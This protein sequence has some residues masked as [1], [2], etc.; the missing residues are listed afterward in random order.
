MSR[1]DNA[2]NRCTQHREEDDAP[3]LEWFAGF[4]PQVGDA[5]GGQK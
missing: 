1:F 3:V 2:A 5:P 4:F